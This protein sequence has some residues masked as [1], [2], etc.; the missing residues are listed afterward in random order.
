MPTFSLRPYPRALQS[1]DTHITPESSNY[2]ECMKTKNCNDHL[3]GN[4]A[5][6]LSFDL[7]G[8]ERF[9][10]ATEGATSSGLPDVIISVVELR[11]HRVHDLVEEDLIGT[12]DLFGKNTHEDTSLR[13][14]HTVQNTTRASLEGVVR[15]TSLLQPTPLRIH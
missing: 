3:L 10:L 1:A 8:L 9:R 2:G 4:D 6:L 13:P 15:M 11:L 12:G 5:R 7:L 14:K